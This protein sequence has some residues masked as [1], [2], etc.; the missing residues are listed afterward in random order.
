MEECA[1]LQGDFRTSWAS[2]EATLGAEVEGRVSKFE[3]KFH[4]GG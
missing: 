3:A 4:R 2:V 1:T